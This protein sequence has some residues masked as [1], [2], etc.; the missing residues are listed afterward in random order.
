MRPGQITIRPK[1]EALPDKEVTALVG[2]RVNTNDP[3]LIKLICKWRDQKDPEQTDNFLK[4]PSKIKE[5]REV[6]K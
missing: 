2:K 6:F 5:L 1:R 3:R 4:Q